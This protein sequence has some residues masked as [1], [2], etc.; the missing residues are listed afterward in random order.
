MA[1]DRRSAGS[2][3]GSF[4]GG[5]FR[6]VLRLFWVMLSGVLVVF[7]LLAGFLLLVVISNTALR[8]LETT[9][10]RSVEK[11]QL[12]EPNLSGLQRAVLFAT[13]QVL[14]L[15]QPGYQMVTP[16]R[17]FRDCADCPDMVEVPKGYFL[18]GSPIFEEGRYVHLFSHTPLRAQFKLANREG[19]RR[20]TRIPRALAFS[21]HEITYGQWRQAQEDPEW[22]AITG[23]E[24]Y[25]PDLGADYRGD[26]PMTL[27]DWSD[28]NAYATYLSTKTGQTY[29]LPTDAE[30]EYAARAGTVTRFPW[31]DD[32]GKNNANCINCSFLWPERKPGPVGLY[33]P[34][35]FGLYDMHGNG[36]EWVEDCFEAYLD[37]VTV[38]GSAFVQEACE[39][40]TI[41]GGGPASPAWQNRSG[42]RV[43]PHYYNR[44]QGHAIR[45][46]RELN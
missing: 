1:F 33:P 14:P 35:D 40:R 44:G 19:P 37:L 46:V 24:P 31:G 43:G 29:R 39:F 27:I 10:R 20:L 25:L 21:Q 36:F 8:D 7:V 12:P 26:Q 5:V 30:W 6:W 23:Q 3:R 15:H 22:Q 13:A 11:E 17:V 42:F 28:A 32:I 18:F 38:D 9:M 2:G 16:G 34:N 45:L 41:R 4:V